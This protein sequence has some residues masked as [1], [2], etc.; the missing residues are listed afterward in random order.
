MAT[1]KEDIK[2]Q[3]D[4]IVKAFQADG[5]NL[6]GSMDSIIEVDRF[7]VQNMKNGKPKKGGRL[8]GKG[9]GPKLFS[10]GSYVG[11]TIIKNVKGAEWITDDNDPKANLMYP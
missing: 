3:S 6:D 10:I 2:T 11:E 8:Y 4:W 9:F 5:F 1:L 7:F